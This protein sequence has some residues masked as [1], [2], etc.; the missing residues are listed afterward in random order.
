[1]VG[2]DV[3]DL[4]D[5]DSQREFAP[6]FD[7][8]VFCEEE[9]ASLDASASRARC[10]W[11][12]WAAKEAAYKV[13]VKS[14]PA[15]VFSPSRFR[16][17]LPESAETGVVE[18]LDRALPVR[19]VVQDDAVHAVASTAPDRLVVGTLRIDPADVSVQGPDAESR[20]VRRFASECLARELQIDGKEVEIRKRGRIPE[21]WTN[22]RCAAADLS[23]SHHG[24]VVGFACEIGG[25][26]S[27]R[28][29]ARASG[30]L[31]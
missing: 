19:V 16:V 11:R 17:H 10:R 27:V 20:A 6:R 23:L 5:E 26:R 18:F 14:D 25:A 3:V 21:L 7:A 12:L 13:A 22:G 4:R 28:G 9:L 31:P 8:R 30:I 1:M 24:N 29:D 15:T 2:N